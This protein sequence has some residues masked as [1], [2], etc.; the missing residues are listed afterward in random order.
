MRFLLPPPP[1]PVELGSL[2]S[3]PEEKEIVESCTLHGLSLSEAI[4]EA[5]PRFPYWENEVGKFSFLHPS[6]EGWEESDYLSW[7]EGV[8]APPQECWCEECGEA[9]GNARP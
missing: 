3:C 2:F 5:G 9:Q 8:N 4:R 6:S 7:W 1:P